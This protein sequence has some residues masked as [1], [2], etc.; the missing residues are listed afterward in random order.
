M[1]KALVKGSG[2]RGV[3]MLGLSYGNLDKLRAEPLDTFIKIEG[4]QFG[5]PHDIIIFSGKTEADMEKMLT[6]DIKWTNWVSVPK[7]VPRAETNRN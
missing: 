3:I 2:K 1:I 5:M 6:T 4:A 7:S